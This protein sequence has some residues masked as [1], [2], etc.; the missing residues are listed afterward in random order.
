MRY[1]IQDN[2][3]DVSNAEDVHEFARAQIEHHVRTA[4]ALL[5]N[6]TI[7]RRCLERVAQLLSIKP[8]IAAEQY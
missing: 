2:D 7:Q 6:A 3:S 1:E 4:L 8:P 5:K